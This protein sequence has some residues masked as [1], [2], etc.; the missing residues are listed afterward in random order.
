MR[1]WDLGKK[2]D[3]RRGRDGD[4]DDKEHVRDTVR[5]ALA[6]DLD[7]GERDRSRRTDREKRRHSESLSPGKNRGQFEQE[8]CNSIGQITYHHY[9]HQL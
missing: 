1:E 6:R 5:G 7:R 4:R 3:N 8:M 9:I 2:P